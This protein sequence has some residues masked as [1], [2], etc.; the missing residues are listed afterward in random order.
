MIYWLKGNLAGSGSGG[1]AVFHAE[2]LVDLLQVFLDGSGTHAKNRRG[3]G[4]CFSLRNPMEY[5]RFHYL[6]NHDKFWWGWGRQ[7]RVRGR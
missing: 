3:L 1:G 7:G 5:L 4:V 6:Y 2:L